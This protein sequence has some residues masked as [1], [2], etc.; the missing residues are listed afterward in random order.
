MKRSKWKGPYINEKILFDLN[1]K[2]NYKI[3]NKNFIIIP[4]FI[5]LTFNVYNGKNFSKL[6]ITEE[7]LGHKL[8][9]FISTRKKFSF[10][11]KKKHK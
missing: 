4:K 3:L 5:G 8:G 2:K 1:F 7:M 9:E 11:K 10:K 6:I